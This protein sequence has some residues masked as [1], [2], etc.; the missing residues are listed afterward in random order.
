VAFVVV[1]VRNLPDDS[2]LLKANNEIEDA[3]VYPFIGF[4]YISEKKI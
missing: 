3:H 2:H 1:L 4:Y